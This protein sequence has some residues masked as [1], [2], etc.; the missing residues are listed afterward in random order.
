MPSFRRFWTWPVFWLAVLAV[1][2]VVRFKPWDEGRQRLIL[3]NNWDDYVESWCT[4]RLL[5]VGHFGLVSFGGYSLLCVSGLWL[6]EPL[7]PELREDVRPLALAALADRPHAELWLR[8]GDWL[9]G[10]SLH[11]IARLAVPNAVA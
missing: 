11:F 10:G 9:F 6:T 7:V 4:L 5:L 2:L 1:V 8:P 3:A